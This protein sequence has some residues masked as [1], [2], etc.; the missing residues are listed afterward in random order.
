MKTGRRVFIN[1]TS[2]IGSRVESLDLRAGATQTKDRERLQF[3]GERQLGR[4]IT[5]EHAR[6]ARWRG[7]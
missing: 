6:S 5:R 3:N 2:V 1:K 7:Q 4:L